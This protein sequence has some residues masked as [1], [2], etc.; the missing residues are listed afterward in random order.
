MTS[1]VHHELIGKSRGFKGD[2]VKPVE[3]ISL[4]VGGFA[5]RNRQWGLAIYW[6]VVS[7][8][9]QLIC[10]VFARRIVCWTTPLSGQWGVI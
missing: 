4:S 1:G 10:A 8:A 3:L 2:S 9:K 5:S 7:F 6:P